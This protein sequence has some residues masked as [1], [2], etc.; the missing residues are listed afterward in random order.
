MHALLRHSLHP[1]WLPVFE[2][3]FAK[4]AAKYSSDEISVTIGSYPDFAPF[5]SRLPVRSRQGRLTN[6]TVGL[7]ETCK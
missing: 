5:A 2:G 3:A 6:R 4:N 1:K 7:R